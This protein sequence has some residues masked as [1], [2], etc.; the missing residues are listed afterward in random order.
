MAK[1]G[2][3]TGALSSH[4]NPV[5]RAA[6]FARTHM[7][8]WLAGV[9][10]IGHA[11]DWLTPPTKRVYTVP[12]R[13]KRVFCELGIAH[14]VEVEQQ[15]QANK[16]DIRVKMRQARAKAEAELRSQ[17]WTDKQIAE[18]FAVWAERQRRRKRRVQPFKEPTL[19][20]VLAVVNRRASPITLR[21][22]ASA[23]TARKK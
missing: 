21:R 5:N 20:Q 11:S 16:G 3:P 22:K 8:L 23:R 12:Q 13:V 14:V 19:K 6:S 18:W 1:R 10:S 4:T 17:G 7:E 2:R 15:T 9:S